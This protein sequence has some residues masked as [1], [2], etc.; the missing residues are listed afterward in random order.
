MLNNKKAKK[1]S[2]KYLNKHVE[3]DL[4]QIKLTS[5]DSGAKIK[6]FQKKP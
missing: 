5:R 3:L 4:K 1:S 6:N 2:Y